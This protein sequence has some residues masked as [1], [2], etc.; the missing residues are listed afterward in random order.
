MYSEIISAIQSVKALSELVK[1]A[2]DLSN[3]AEF[4]TAV[5]EISTKLMS[6]TAVALASQEKQ[7]TLTNR[8]S[9]L[10][11]Q[12]RKIEDWERNIKRYK[13]YEFPTR[14]LA[15]VLQQDMQQEEPMHYLCTS[16]V[17]KRQKSILQP[18]R[19][20]LHCPVCKTDIS[21][22]SASPRRNR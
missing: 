18:Y 8:I 15:Y 17:D 21:I 5:S 20:F 11:N 22:Q 3:Y 13:L 2:H 16:C 9:E 4:I 19:N 6:A 7:S 10:E 12:L 1:A 14:A